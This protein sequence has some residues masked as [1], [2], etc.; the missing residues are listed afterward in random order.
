MQRFF[1]F[2]VSAI[3]ISVASVAAF[4]FLMTSEPVFAG[5]CPADKRVVDATKAVARR[6][7]SRMMRALR[8]SS[9]RHSA[10]T[11]CAS[12]CRITRFQIASWSAPSC[13]TPA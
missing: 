1:A 3:A 10:N 6:L 9:V 11:S 8:S 4:T 2:S 12:A 13:R 5:E 7:R